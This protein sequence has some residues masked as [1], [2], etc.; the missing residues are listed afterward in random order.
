MEIKG[1]LP[2]SLIVFGIILIN[3]QTSNYKNRIV[4]LV[5]QTARWSTAAIQDKN[6]YIQ[7]LHANYA[8]G[9]I[10][11]L[12]GNY[13][14]NEIL[15]ATGVN[16]RELSTKVTDIQNMALLNLAKICPQGA[17]KDQFLAKIAKQK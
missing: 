17:P 4:T 8:Q 1:I 5:R 14:E 12:Q 6:P 2:L 16:I 15:L 11:A 7:N 3:Y 9:Y 13:S 10:M